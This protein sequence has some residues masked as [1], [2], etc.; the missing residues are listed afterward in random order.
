[1]NRCERMQILNATSIWDIVCIGIFASQTVARVY[2]SR[3]EVAFFDTH[4]AEGWREGSKI[5][6][7][8]RGNRSQG[9]L[10]MSHL[11]PFWKVGCSGA[12]HSQDEGNLKSP[13]HLHACSLDPWLLF[14][15]L[16]RTYFLS[17]MLGTVVV[18]LP[19]LKP[20]R[21]HS[22]FLCSSWGVM[23]EMGSVDKFV[24]ALG[25]AMVSIHIVAHV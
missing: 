8:G 24:L 6:N 23:E 18:C 5:R 14:G 12:P 1:M 7:G 15:L 25:Y 17:L 3:A 20:V 2:I 16:I 19:S 22:E 10:I 11:F 21:R 4:C 13:P 9:L